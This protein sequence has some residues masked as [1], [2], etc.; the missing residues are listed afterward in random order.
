MRRGRKS[1]LLTDAFALPDF[2]RH[3]VAA[4]AGGKEFRCGD[5]VIHFRPTEA[6]RVKLA[7]VSDRR[8]LACRR[9]IQQLADDRRHGNVEDLSPCLAGQ[10]PEAEMNRYL[11][12]KGFTHAPSLLGDVVRIAPDGTPSTLAIALEFVRNEGDAWSWMLDHLNRALDAH[13]PASR[14][15]EFRGRSVRRLRCRLLAAIGRR[16]GEMHA[17]LARETSDPAFAPE[18]A[19]TSDAADWAKKAEERLQKAFEAIAQTANLGARPGSGTR[20]EA[21]EPAREH[22]GAVRNLANSG[23][24]TLKTRIHGDFHLGQVLVASGDA[25]IIDFEG[26]PAASIDGAPDQN[27]SAARRRWTASFDRL[28]RRHIDRRERRSA[29]YRWMKRSATNSSHNSARAAVQ[30]P[31]RLLGGS[32]RSEADRRARVTRSVFDRKSCLRNRLRGR[33][34]RPG[35]GCQSPG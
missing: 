33:Q 32:R 3:V 12:A 11:T 28:C 14:R 5:G 15:R 22:R 13:A 6:G 17:I 20:A 2:A 23:T 7:N 21:F 26:E 18:I 31:E 10:H 16:L 8:S 4:L 27:E 25:Y 24:G 1:G 29:P 35:S 30:L 9:T 34:R 19:D